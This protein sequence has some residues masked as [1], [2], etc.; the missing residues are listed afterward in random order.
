MIVLFAFLLALGI[1]VDDAI[2]VIENTHR[3]FDNGKV[4]IKKAAKLAAGEVFLP[5]LSGTLTTLA[6]F[7][8]LAFWQGVIGKFMFFLPVKLIITLLA[9]LV[10]AYIINPVFAV[11]FMKTHEEEAAERKNTKGFK[12]TSVV[13]AVIAIL[14]YLG[15]GVGLGNFAVVIYLLY[16]LNRFILYKAIGNFQN[17]IWPSFQERYRKIITWCLFGKRP[18]FILLGT[19]GLL[20]FSFFLVSIRTPKIVFFP[21]ASPNFVYT[22]IQL[23]IGT[24]Q[25]KTDSITKLVEERIYKEIGDS[26]KIVESVISNVAIGAGDPSQFE[27]GAQSHLGKV[28][29]AFV[30]FG[31][32]NGEET[33]LYLDRIRNVVKDI[34][35]A[36][37]T[38]EQEKGGPPT[39]KPVNIEIIGDEFDEL[40][41]VS[42]DLKRYLDSLQIPGIEELKSDLVT[43]KPEILVEVDRERAN[44]EGITSSQIGQAL[45]GAIFGIE[46][47]KFKDANDDYP[48]QVRYNVNQRNNI[49]ALMNLKITY[50]DMNMGGQLRSVPLSSVAKLKYSQTYGGI[51]RKNQKRMVTLGSNV[52]V[53]Y[54]ANEVVAQVIK[55]VAK[56]D[57]PKA[58]TVDMT[59]EQEQ[60]AETGAFL[61]RA[62][63]ISLGLIFL[64]LVT[65][66][67]SLS[68][69]VII[70]SEIIF[71]IIGVL[72]GFSI[73]KMDMS[74]LMTGIGIVALAGI[75]VR[76]GILLV[77]FTDIL[78]DNGMEL[79]EAIIEAGRTRMTPVILTA[80]A[81]ILGLVPLAVGL[82][83]D[84]VTLFTHGNPHIYFGGDSVAFWGPLSWTMIFG[85]LFA[86]I[87]TLILVPVMLL[88]SE[89]LKSKIFKTKPQGHKKEDDETI[90]TNN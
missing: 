84:F 2:V 19:I 87:L 59:G 8:P 47:S 30:E 41:T 80:S 62:M 54:N 88:L 45:R 34:P 60:Q 53:G 73:F 56:F 44:R 71:S 51:K 63:L 5:V 81:T 86:T 27:A 16:C 7:I 12:I 13:F 49:D 90:L 17:K 35:G 68:K 61:G 28:T 75:V 58:V 38:V 1:V 15:G 22:Y 85:L 29:V 77:E 39:G 3:I 20:F 89:N 32:R 23:P 57:L 52:L 83:I 43:N 33:L 10:V 78:I 31:K 25:V 37:I 66:F 55:A 4:P 82:N 65:Q 14:S 18:I 6:P 26:N 24:D 9:S 50:R 79:K 21:Q 40:T 42:K 70:L 48:I 74:I 76:N 64:I 46:V 67:N 11:G 72:L 36:Q 69:P